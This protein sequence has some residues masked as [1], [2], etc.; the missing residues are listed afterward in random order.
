[1]KFDWHD[2]KRKSN[3]EKHDLDF[4]DAI[5]VFEQEYFVEDRTR[6]EEGKRERQPLGHF[7]KRTSQGIG[8][9]I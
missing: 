3:I 9:G 4:L 7:L 1:M 5:Q 6:E 8:P 2:E